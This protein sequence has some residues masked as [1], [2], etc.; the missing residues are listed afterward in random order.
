MGPGLGI[1]LPRYGARQERELDDL[2]A[3]PAEEPPAVAGGLRHLHADD[4][5]PGCSTS[6]T[7]RTSCSS[8]SRPT[9]AS[10]QIPLSRPAVESHLFG[11]YFGGGVD[12]R[13]LE[14]DGD[15]PARVH[16]GQRS[17]RSCR[18]PPGGTSPIPR[19]DRKGRG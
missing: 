9:S 16:V 12:A 6:D 4:Q 2:V 19:A 15:G 17:Y 18:R 8:S 3:S 13:I 1:F 5:P 7:R 10:R 14:S 11:T